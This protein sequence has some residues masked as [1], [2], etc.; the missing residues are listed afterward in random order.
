MCYRCQAV[1]GGS[2]IFQAASFPES[3]FSAGFPELQLNLQK[4]LCVSP[5]P[6]PSPRD[7]AGLQKKEEEQEG[8]GVGHSDSTNPG[9]K[10]L[11]C[12]GELASCELFGSGYRDSTAFLS[13]FGAVG[14]EKKDPRLRTPRAQPLSSHFSLLP[15]GILAPQQASRVLAAYQGVAAP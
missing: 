7:F 12:F 9:G 2:G 5:P 15:V 14:G 11:F 4:C 3:R 13:D 6:L 1:R 8:L 10:R